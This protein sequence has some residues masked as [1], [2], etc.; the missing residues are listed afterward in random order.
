M[1]AE[2]ATPVVDA[3]APP[4]EATSTPRRPTAADLARRARRDPGQPGLGPYT[5]P[6]VVA[7]LVALVLAVGL[8][9]SLVGA[10]RAP[11]DVS[12]SATILG[13]FPV[14]PDA[15]GIPP[16]PAGQPDAAVP[17]EAVPEAAPPVP[18]PTEPGAAP[19]TAAPSTGPEVLDA[20]DGGFE[21]WETTGEGWTVADGALEVPGG[22]TDEPAWALRPGDAAVGIGA[23]VGEPVT[24]VGLVVG[25]AGPDD[26]VAAVAVPDYGGW[27]LEVWQDGDV[28]SDTPLAETDSGT[29]VQ[30]QV[31]DGEARLLVGGAVAGTLP[32][33]GP[34]GDQVGFLSRG[35]PGA[36]WAALLAGPGA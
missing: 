14:D 4:T 29:Q 5:G 18:T 32:A 7:A 33:P 9:I 21:G 36:R 10:V 31:V 30:L 25:V 23:E 2:P 28:T 12:N 22:S 35:E 15:P 27:R 8:L 26:Y 6:A 1:P 19:T 11:D 16:G 20:F 24:E 34:V 17:P 3:E 13:T